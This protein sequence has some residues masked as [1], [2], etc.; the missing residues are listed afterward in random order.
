MAESAHSARR[1]LLLLGTLVEIAAEAP[2]RSVLESAFLAARGELVRIHRGLS[3]HDAGSE[4]SR[5]NALAASEPQPISDDLRR[6]LSCALDIAARSRGVFDPTVGAQVAA[7]GFLPLQAAAPGRA[8]WRDVELTGQTVRYAKPLVLDFGGIA[9]GYAVDCA[10]EALRANGASAG[11]VNAGGDLR[12]F[13]ARSEPVH[14]RTG[15]PQGAVF[16]LVHLAE[17]AVA[18]SAYGGQRRRRDRRWAS[19]LVDPR[20]RL[21]VLSTRTASVIAP[22]CMVADALTKV[23]VLLGRGARGVLRA[24]G[25][26]AVV[27]SPARGRW[28]CTRLDGTMVAAA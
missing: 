11:R 27:L 20:L 28:R 10:I 7:L 15:G 21:P 19:P 2:S 13:G 12:V 26:D 17:G 22:T 9:K 16:P 18:T 8:S 3:G 14:I 24:Y 1:S 5:V 23:V 6:V 25:A 4:L